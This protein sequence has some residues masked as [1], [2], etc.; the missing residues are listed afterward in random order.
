ML[1]SPGV[2]PLSRLP[3]FRPKGMENAPLFSFYHSEMMKLP[4]GAHLMPEVR[5]G[6]YFAPDKVNIP[7]FLLNPIPMNVEICENARIHKV[8]E[9]DTL[10]ASMGGARLYS[11]SG[12]ISLMEEIRIFGKE[13]GQKKRYE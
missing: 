12:F 7:I 2:A 3:I 4:E 11:M 6:D 1:I 10:P 13:G 5:Y 8:A 9:G